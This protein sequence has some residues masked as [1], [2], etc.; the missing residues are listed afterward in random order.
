M[1][2]RTH[3]SRPAARIAAAC[4]L[5]ASVVGCGI[6]SQ[7]PPPLTGP[8]EFGT[9]V[10]LV[11]SPDRVPR[12]GV[13][14]SIVTVRVF[15]ENGRPKANQSLLVGALPAGTGL[16]QS[17]IVTDANGVAT[18]AVTA[19]PFS[20]VAPNNQIVVQV[21]PRTGNNANSIVRTI[22]I[23]LLGSPNS[24]RPTA[25]FVFTPE[26]PD[27]GQ[28]IVFDASSSTDEGVLC[29]DDCSY[30]WDF[31]GTTRTG[32]V[33]SHSFSTTGTFAVTLTV[34]DST[35]ATGTSV[36][37]I[38]VGAPAAP[39]ADFI[40]SPTNPTA[41]AT[42]QFNASTTTVGEGATIV[43]YAWDFG[44]G[45]TGTGVTDST[46]YAAPGTFNVL[47]TVTDN[48]GRTNSTTKT[49]TVQ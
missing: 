18:F 46:Q 3:F 35:G 25:S 15:D 28:I 49:V 20:A 41:G 44:N 2:I 14:Q 24:T 16:S 42:V 4:A 22:P 10:S 7:S 32:R 23:G 1:Q 31:S 29:G 21:S 13:S 6:E 26:A 48:L 11:A 5:A 39:D 8:S 45:D 19:P 36:Q 40:F 37:G 30:T 12:D 43:S 27:V 17:E 34:T 47:L 38:D 33:A 9:S